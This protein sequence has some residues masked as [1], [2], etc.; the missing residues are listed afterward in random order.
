[1]FE[2]LIANNNIKNYF[3][4]CFQNNTINH[5]YAFIGE[6]GMGKSVASNEL[7]TQI[8]LWSSGDTQA[9]KAS[10]KISPD[11]KYITGDEKKNLISVDDIRSLSKDI[12]VKPNE[13][14]VKIYIILN[15][16]N[17]N[18]AAQNAFLKIL[19][20]PPINVYFIL[21]A[22]SKGDL[23]E[24]V[25]S[26]IICLDMQP[27]NLDEALLFFNKNK[28]DSAFLSAYNASMG[29]L[30]LLKSLYDDKD[31]YQNIC[32]CRD[33]LRYIFENKS[34]EAIKIIK[35]FSDNALHLTSFFNIIKM[36]LRDVLIKHSKIDNL[37]FD[38]D[39]TDILIEKI[40]V[41][42]ALDITERCNDM[43]TSLEC[44]TPCMLVGINFVALIK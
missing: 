34:Y 13:A 20:E 37:I 16:G 44:Y 30:G 9:A 28:N 40:D 6:K 23:L 43:I 42:R 38:N 4:K 17:M 18:V 25:L 15:A 21:T 26:R 33:F 7:A 10:K 2:K 19:E 27:I 1:M 39:I 35:K 22:T 29:N 12:Y 24:T 5:A 31:Y 14:N 8:M 41:G 32:L 3:E 11:V 36:I